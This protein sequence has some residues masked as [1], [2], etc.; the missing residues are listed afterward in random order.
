MSN[1]IENTIK[2]TGEAYNEILLIEARTFR[3]QNQAI[4]PTAAIGYDAAMAAIKRNNFMVLLLNTAMDYLVRAHDFAEQGNMAGWLQ[5][6]RAANII[7]NRR[8]FLT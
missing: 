2:A 4:D 1:E 8:E 7:R 3:L 6:V 5:F